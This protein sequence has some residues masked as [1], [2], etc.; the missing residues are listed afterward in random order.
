M[1]YGIKILLFIVLTFP[2]AMMYSQTNYC[3]EFMLLIQ[4]YKSKSYNDA[5][6]YLDTVM[7]KCPDQINS[8]YYWHLSGVI[9]YDVFRFVDNKSPISKARET[10]ISSFLQSNKLDKKNKFSVHNNQGLSHIATSYYNDAAIILQKEDTVNYDNAIVFYN[11]YKE[12]KKKVQPDYDFSEKDLSY[13]HVMGN[14]YKYKYE[15]NKQFYRSYV[16]SAIVCYNRALDIDSNNFETLYALGILYHNLGVDI[17]LNDLEVDADLE[18]VII[19][20]EKAIGYFSEALPYLKKIHGFKP[21]D[22]QIVHGLA[23]V[24]F[25]LND[26]EQHVKYMNVLR[27]LKNQPPS[28]K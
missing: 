16:D 13:N 15:N 25:S 9:Y 3:P 14:I 26:M 27:E 28:N 12:L 8:A 18:K 22:K 4:K 23:A 10:S 2:T 11:K 24:Y 19:M 17:I 5:K 21:S 1:K 20:Q 7:L 6:L